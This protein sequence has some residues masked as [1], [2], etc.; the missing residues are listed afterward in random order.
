MTL[1]NFIKLFVPNSLLS[2][3]HLVL[4]NLAALAY[5]HPSKN[6]IVIGVTGTN[7][8]STT[9][10]L[11]SKILEEAG[12][13]T[14]ISSTVN[15]KVGD[16]D[17]LNNLKM[18]MPGRLFLQH[19][20][21]QAVT[22]GCQ[23]M[24]I[25]SSSE[26]ILQHRQIGV[27][28]DC[29]VFTNL[30]PEH[31]QAHGGFEKY[32][33]AKLEYFHYLENLPEKII[34]NKKIPK[35]IVVNADDLYAQEFLNFRVDKK[36]TFSRHGLRNINNTEA[37]IGF[38][39]ENV[40]FNLHLKGLFDIYNS[41]AAITTAKIFDIDLATS[42]SALEKIPG[43]PGRMELIDEGQN[44]KVLVDYAP[45]PIGLTQ[46]YATVQNWQHAK[47]IHVLGSTGGGRDIDRRKILGN[48]AGENADTVIVT[49]ED[50][51]N[52]D[53]RKIIDDV[54]AGALEK[55]KILDQNLFKIL[56]RRQAIMK[57]ISLAQE[58]DLIILTGKGAEQ[59]IAVKD[60]YI[61]W[62]DRKIVR[63]IIRQR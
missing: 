44:F 18:T 39:F 60:G 13:K 1:K 5:G 7:G 30:T 50:P 9:V 23:F 47:I 8:K 62:D 15:F 35:A 27:A 52:D 19:L 58:N 2:I 36:I 63:E 57:A 10:N 37:G 40:D 49:N 25:E 55:N 21:R 31:L 24:I 46:M 34:D 54:A 12:Y 53:P 45:E 43:I 61:P 59:K 3:Y 29:M 14:A 17:K 48:I 4:A 16:D 38:T 56:D 32:K 51:Y 42:K 28:Y 33:A 22:T 6:L 11:I 20:M 41:L 26:G